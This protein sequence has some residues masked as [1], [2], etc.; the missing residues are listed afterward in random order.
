MQIGKTSFEMSMPNNGT[1]RT[2]SN[3]FGRG[4]LVTAWQLAWAAHAD[5]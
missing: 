3:R 1:E 5:R 2:R 4:E